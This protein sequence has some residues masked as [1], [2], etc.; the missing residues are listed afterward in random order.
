MLK[1]ITWILEALKLKAGGTKKEQ[2]APMSL[3][4]K[5]VVFVC[6]EKKL[7]NAR[8]RCEIAGTTL[9]EV[10]AKEI[11]WMEKW[12]KAEMRDIWKKENLP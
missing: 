4:E 10:S 3:E 2:K 12:I 8:G 6:L 7:E 5:K 11:A 1:V 9:L